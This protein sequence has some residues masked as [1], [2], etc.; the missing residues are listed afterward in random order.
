MQPKCMS[1]AAEMHDQG[2][3]NVQPN[4]AKIHEGMQPKCN[5]VFLKKKDL[6]QM[7]NPQAKEVDIIPKVR[8]KQAKEVDIIPKVRFKQIHYIKTIDA[9]CGQS[10]LIIAFT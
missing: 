9:S 6:S 8:F 3:Q 10:P 4:A 1:E 2:S 7:S 5:K